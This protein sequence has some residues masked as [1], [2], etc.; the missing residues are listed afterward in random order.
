MRRFLITAVIVALALAAC[1]KKSP[2]ATAVPPTVTRPPTATS[3]P[4]PTVLPTNTAVPATATTGSTATALPTATPAPTVTPTRAVTPTFP[5][6]P[7]ATPA[8]TGTST[9][10]NSTVPI[11][12]PPAPSRQTIQN[13]ALPSFSVRVSTP[14]IWVNRDSLAH[15]ASAAPAS[16]F[17]WDSGSI[18]GGA[19]SRAIVFS[20]TG[21]F[22]YFCAIHSSMQGTVTV[23]P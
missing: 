15:T 7:T 20:Q 1:G 18:G 23:T 2:T 8:P 19:E 4:A 17:Q 12:P 6:T 16:A 10:G 9:G 14:V 21:S 5:P 13:F 11:P 22:A 3:A